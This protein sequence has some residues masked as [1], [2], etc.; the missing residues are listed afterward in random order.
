M[1]DRLHQ[2]KNS[3]DKEGDPSDTRFDVEVPPR[4][5]L[6]SLG[7]DGLVVRKSPSNKSGVWE[8]VEMF[9]AAVDECRNARRM[10][11]SRPAPFPA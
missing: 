6:I 8:W 3:R 2:T 7:D 10:E 4:T 9:S 1:V 5:A 11:S